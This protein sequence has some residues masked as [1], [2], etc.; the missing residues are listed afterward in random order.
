M[1]VYQSKLNKTPF[2]GGFEVGSI[3]TFPKVNPG[4]TVA[5]VDKKTM[6]P[7]NYETYYYDIKRANKEGKITIEKLHDYLSTYD[8]KDLRPSN[9]K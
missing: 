9:L 3:T 4:F 7:L 1:Q 2:L 8:L 5:T 6:L